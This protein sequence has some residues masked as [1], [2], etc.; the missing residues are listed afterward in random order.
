MLTAIILTFNEAEHIAR[1][2]QS[3]QGACNRIVVLDSH[4]TDGTREIAARLGADVETRVFQNQ[5]NQFNWALDNCEIS[6]GWVLRL[7]ADEVVDAT[8]LNELKKFRG[9]DEFPAAGFTVVRQFRFLERTL[10]YGGLGAIRTLRLFKH[11]KGRAEQR[12]MDEHIQVCGVIGKLPGRIIDHN[13]KPLAWWIQKHNNYASREV[14]D[15]LYPARTV[16]TQRLHWRARMKRTLKTSIFYRLPL[17][18]GPSCYFFTRYAL[19]L[20]FADGRPGLIYHF[21]QAFWYR[22]LVQAKLYEIQVL[23]KQR[24]FSQ[25]NAVLEVTGI[26]PP[27]IGAAQSPATAQTS[28][29]DVGE[30]SGRQH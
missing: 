28:A 17:L 24:G 19:L 7:D 26:R 18:I 22:G 15:I 3:L 5:A 29:T 10:Q 8:L 2:I 30:E 1:C 12:W 4:S 16:A 11:G 21:L 27:E 20:G 13:L 9:R 25:A 23:Q 14:I 6:E